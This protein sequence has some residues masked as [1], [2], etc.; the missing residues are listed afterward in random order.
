MSYNLK[1]GS[2]TVGGYEQSVTDRKVGLAKTV[3]LKNPE[4]LCIQESKDLSAS[5]LA[6][7][8]ASNGTRTYTSYQPGGSTNAILWDASLYTKLSGGV[9]DVTV[10]EGGDGYTRTAVWIKF[11]RKSDGAQFIVIS[12]HFDLNSP[13]TTLTNMISALESTIGST[14]TVIMGDLNANEARWVNIGQFRNLGYSNANTAYTDFLS[15]HKI[16]G[17]NAGWSDKVDGTAADNG[18]AATFPKNGTILDWCYYTT[19]KFAKQ[20]YEVVTQTVKWTYSSYQTLWQDKSITSNPSDHY[21]I[22]VT[23]T[24]E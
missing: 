3:A 4:I 10:T 8:C 14:R 18:L 11:Q 2:Y 12:T 6:S 21:P 17:G 1:D 19:G 20:T 7:S 22:Y 16:T 9:V 15:A 5:S 23:L 24:L 13:G